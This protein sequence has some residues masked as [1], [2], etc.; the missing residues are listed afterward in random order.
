[1]YDYPYATLGADRPGF[2]TLLQD[3]LHHFGYTETLAYR[4][5]PYRQLMHGR[6]RVHVDILTHP[7]DPTMTA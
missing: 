2:L 1:M 5:R 6:C 7:S 3:V 4:G